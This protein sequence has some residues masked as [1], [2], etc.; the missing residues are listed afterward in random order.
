[1]EFRFKLDLY[2]SHLYHFFIGLDEKEEKEGCHREGGWGH[3]IEP[4]NIFG[5]SKTA[6]AKWTQ[7]MFGCSRI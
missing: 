6:C 4:K 5:D 2:R 1:M 3:R 7:L